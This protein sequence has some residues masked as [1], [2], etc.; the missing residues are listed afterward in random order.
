MKECI[1]TAAI[2]KARKKGYWG[3]SIHNDKIYYHPDEQN[4]IDCTGIAYYNLIWC[5][6]WDKE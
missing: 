3:V 1:R 2:M 4:Y 6:P 5:T